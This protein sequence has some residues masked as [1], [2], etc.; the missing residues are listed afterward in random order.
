MEVTEKLPQM[1][2]A[3]GA[4]GQHNVQEQR[5]SCC[6]WGES[7]KSRGCCGRCPDCAA[8]GE[9]QVPEHSSLQREAPVT[10]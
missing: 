4:Y 3:E 10:A 6:W 1:L 8:G 9:Q 2:Q 5:L 7:T